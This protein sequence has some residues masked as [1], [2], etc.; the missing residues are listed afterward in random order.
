MELKLVNGKYSASKLGGFETVGGDEELIQRI[1]MKL[2]ARRGGFALMPEYGSRLYL[3]ANMHASQREASARQYIA[4]ALADEP[5]VRLEALDIACVGEDGLHLT[6]E[7]SA[8]QS[9]FELEWGDE[10]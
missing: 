9:G 6:M 7:F 4:E 3:L 2:C 10:R 8:G 1:E 5:G